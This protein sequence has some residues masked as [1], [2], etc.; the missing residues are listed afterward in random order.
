M[1]LLFYDDDAK[2]TQNFRI[3]YD[4]SQENLTFSTAQSSSLFVLRRTRGRVG[5]NTSTPQAKL[6]VKD[7]RTGAPGPVVRFEIQ[8]LLQQVILKKF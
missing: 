6:H 3:G 7:K 2:T 1:I 5:I 8:I 4:A